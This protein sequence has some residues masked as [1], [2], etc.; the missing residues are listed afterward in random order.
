MLDLAEL[1]LALS[2]RLLGK[3]VRQ[4]HLLRRGRRA[5]G[6]VHGRRGVVVR[7]KIRHSIGGGAL[8]LRLAH[9]WRCGRIGWS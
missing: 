7:E 5:G 1:D 6:S 8:L 4:R 3:M 9:L 2:E